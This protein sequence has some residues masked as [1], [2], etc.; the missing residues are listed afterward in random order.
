[1]WGPI[2][3]WVKSAVESAMIGDGN[4]D[5]MVEAKSAEEV[6]ERLKDYRNA[7]GRFKL[8]WDEQW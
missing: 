6:I 7:G 4:C 8:K 2:L 5:T 3:Q 1:Y